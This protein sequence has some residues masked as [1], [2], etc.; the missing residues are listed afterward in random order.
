MATLQSIFM[1]AANRNTQI[2]SLAGTT[3]STFQT[4]GTSDSNTIFVITANQAI[5]IT[6]GVS[7]SITTPDATDWPIWANS[8][9]IFALP[10]GATGF[11]VFNT[12]GSAALVNYWQL[13]RD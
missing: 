3:A 13:S 5:T 4:I 7:A 6:F 10:P 2:G 9:S 8:Y 12:S 11:K 1:P